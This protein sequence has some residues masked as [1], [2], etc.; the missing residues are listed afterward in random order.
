[1]LRF[2]ALVW[3]AEDRAAAQTAGRMAADLAVDG[4]GL[5]CHVRAP[6]MVVYAE[7]SSGSNSAWRTYPLA[8]GRGVILG[9][10]FRTPQINEG[11]ACTEITAPIEEDVGAAGCKPLVTRYW[12]TY[13]AFIAD[14]ARRQT[15]VLRDC[16]GKIPCYTLRTPEVD[17]IFSSVS[18]ICVV[19]RDALALNWE[20]LAVFI[21]WNDVQTRSSALQGVSEVL[22]GECLV[23]SAGRISRHFAWDPRNVCR[24]E[25]V[26]DSATAAA[27][28]RRTALE[29]IQA[30]CSVYPR[31]L[32]LLSGGFDSAVVLGCMRLAGDA[33][34]VVCLNRYNNVAGEDER[35]YARLAARQAG[36]ELLEVPLRQG[37]SYPDFRNL[38]MPMTVRPSVAQLFDAV[39]APLLHEVAL[40]TGSDSIW[41]GQGGDHLFLRSSVA[42]GAADYFHAHGLRPRL[43]SVVRDAARLSKQPYWSVIKQVLSRNG[44]K[45]VESFYD[46]ASPFLAAAHPRAG[47]DLVAQTRHPWFDDADDLPNGKRLQLLMLAELLNRHA[48]F[49][50][51]GTTPQHHPLL[52]QPIVEACLRI[53]TYVLLQEGRA[54]SLA[55]TAFSS[56]I[57]REIVARES[58]GATTSYVTAVVRE[59]MAYIRELLLDGNLASHRVIDPSA[60]EPFLMGRRLMRP[61]D[62][63]PLLSCIAAELWT[64][65]WT[66]TIA[67]A[68]A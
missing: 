37:E 7:V 16:S 57:P 54:R 8:R 42:V 17:L 44:G 48:Q 61:H 38:Q 52:S 32:H 49:P 22:A 31:V 60:L 10:L 41:T 2:I 62:F 3:R 14:A 64:R 53:P 63:F 43:L 55:R 18:D 28:L 20:Y 67:R 4:R 68:A 12:G 5:E 40:Q 46:S 66:T 30:W 21:R 25:T 65:H 29:C 9:R 11:T 23:F 26:E 39:E 6:G 34:K 19:A 45:E 56:E 15:L 13:V 33:C 24:E 47:E 1:M 58:K 35:T 59:N 27:L 51:L 36:V 50:G